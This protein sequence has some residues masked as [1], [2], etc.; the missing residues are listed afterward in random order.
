LVRISLAGG[1]E[2]E[3]L[4]LLNSM[5]AVG[6][7]RDLPILCVASLTEQIRAH[8]HRFR[9]DTCAV[10]ETQ[11]ET[12]LRDPAL[13]R[14][15]LWWRDV[16][17]LRNLAQAYSAIA[18]HDWRRALDSILRGDVPA[19]LSSCLDQHVEFLGLQALALERCG[20]DSRPLLA[21]ALDLAKTYGYQKIFS[22]AHPALIDMIGKMNIMEVSRTA[23]VSVQAPVK[24]AEHPKVL[25]FATSAAL[26][27]KEREV[28]LL[29]AHNLSNKEIGLAMQLSEQTVKWHIKNLFIKLDAGT[30]RQV[31]DRARM[32]GL[33]QGVSSD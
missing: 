15:P 3:A 14:G 19:L 10:L 1:K 28:V 8:S 4:H 9:A 16:D 6:V 31:V 22:D 24:L 25:H 2:H 12:F 11:I 26:T 20:E 18:A 30:R 17:V 32:L 29:L 27:P 5:Y 33:L 7:A 23:Q 13:R 21:E